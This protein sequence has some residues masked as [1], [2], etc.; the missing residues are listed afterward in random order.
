MYI[1]ASPSACALRGN[2][3]VNELQ[4][5]DGS[6]R[7]MVTCYVRKG[8]AVYRRKWDQFGSAAQVRDTILC[9]E[10]QH[11]WA[12]RLKPPTSADVERIMQ[13]SWAAA[14]ASKEGTAASPPAKTLRSR[15]DSPNSVT[16]AF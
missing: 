7:S 9:A 1:D 10:P 5:L 14:T 11:G 6:F 4:D 3:P 16:A 2:V 12:E 8:C 13:E 15:A